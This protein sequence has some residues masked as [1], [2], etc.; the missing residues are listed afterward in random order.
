MENSNGRKIN[1]LKE[2]ERKY[3]AKTSPE[4]FIHP[5]KV[6]SKSFKFRFYF[7]ETLLLTVRKPVQ[8][9]RRCIRGL[10]F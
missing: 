2:R 1:E 6:S 9:E 3:I 5:K 10:H 7:T 4:V 8:H